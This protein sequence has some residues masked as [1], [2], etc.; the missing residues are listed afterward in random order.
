MTLGELQEEQRAFLMAL[1]D[2]GSV[3]GACAIMDISRQT[4]YRWR[5]ASSEFD[6]AWDEV[7][8]E[9]PRGTGTKQAF[10]EALPKYGPV[11]GAC[12]A[13][14]VTT[15]TAYRWRTADPEFKAAWDEIIAQR[16]LLAYN[17]EGYRV[18]QHMLGKRVGFEQGVEWVKDRLAERGIEVGDL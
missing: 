12:K 2:C 11:T 9:R 7:V 13:I 3:R 10:L 8:G 1:R 6:A 4:A 18:S 16:E 5:A 14:G 17:N 15:T